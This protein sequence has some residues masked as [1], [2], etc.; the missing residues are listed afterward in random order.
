MAAAVGRL[1]DKLAADNITVLLSFSGTLF[2]CSLGFG[3]LF[4]VGC[5]CS[6]FGG[7]DGGVILAVDCIALVNL[8]C[9]TVPALLCY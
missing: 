3:P 2:F 8:C 6:G 5:P 7:A 1:V 4:I 9:C